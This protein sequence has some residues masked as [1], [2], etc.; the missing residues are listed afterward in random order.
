MKKL[1]KIIGVLLFVAILS[2]VLLSRVYGVGIRIHDGRYLGYSGTTSEWLLLQYQNI[3]VRQDGPYVF[4]GDDGRY[5]LTIRGDGKTPSKTYRNNITSEIEVTADNDKGT[6]FVVPLRKNYPRSI[7]NIPNPKHMLV[8]SDLEGEFDALVNILQVNGV[9]DDSL[10]WHYGSGHLVLIGDMVDR[11]IN[12]VPSLWLIYKLEAEA[13]SAGGDIHYVLGNHERYLLDG[14]V[15]SVAKKYFGSFRAT[16]LSQKELWS[17]NSELGRWLRSK[18]ALLKIGKTLFAHGG[19]SAKILNLNPTLEKVDTEVAKGFTIENS[20]QRTIENSLLHDSLGIL[21]YRG[22][23][24]D[25]SKYNLGKKAG[26]EHVELILSRFGVDRIAI[27]HSL[28]EHVSYDY[29]GK[30][31]RVDVNHAEEKSEALLFEGGLLWR[32]DNK[33]NKFPLEQVKNYND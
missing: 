29:G 30:V 7:L 24:Q 26:D 17:E 14:R 22:L 15:K 25:M 8:I 5:A 18:P 28:A 21:F 3:P 2:I 9:I 13:Q 12:V 32:V 20:T 10:N 11:G 19:I 4:N 6:Q 1:L 23:A 27:G 31:I 33:G 16:G